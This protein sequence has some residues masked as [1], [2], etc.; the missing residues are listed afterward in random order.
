MKNIRNRGFIRPKITTMPRSKSEASSQLELYKL[1]TEQQ[2]I[3]QELQFIE[4]RTALLKQRLSSLKKQIAETEKDINKLR[5][6]DSRP[7]Q[8][9][10]RPHIFFETSNYQ[11]FEI[12][13]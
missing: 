10:K 7:P 13:Y 4:Q 2:R 3:K 9:P 12:E 8:L 11:P 5:Q 6:S 1:V